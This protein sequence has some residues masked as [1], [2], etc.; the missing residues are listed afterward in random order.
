MQGLDTYIGISPIT[1]MASKNYWE[2]KNKVK[3]P[4]SFRPDYDWNVEFAN[5]LIASAAA[6]NLNIYFMPIRI[7]LNK[8]F[9][10]IKLI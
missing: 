2:V 6:N 5:N 4:V 10:R 7:D 9:E 3:F 1:T 8:Y